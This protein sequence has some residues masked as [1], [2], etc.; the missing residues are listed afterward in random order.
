MAILVV[1]GAGFIGS[2][3]V[4]TLLGAGYPVVVLDNFCTGHRDALVGGAL[5]EA[6]LGNTAALT[7]LFECHRIDAVIHFASFIEVGESVVN[8]G[9]YY[10]NNLCG[11]LNL[12]SAMVQANVRHCIFS[13]SAAVYGSPTVQGGL[14]EQHPTHPINPY[15]RSKWMVE[16]L[17]D[18]FHHAHGIHYMALR[19]FNAAGADPDGEL[20]DRLVP[21]PFAGAG[22][23]AGR[24]REYGHQ[25]GKWRRIFHPLRHLCRGKSNRT[26][27]SS[28][29]CRTQTWRYS[30][31]DRQCRQSQNGSPVATPLARPR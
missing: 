2:I 6:D 20:G 13:S 28:D 22:A 29:V 15:G 24:R 1:G 25:P 17:L 9:K 8:P 23:S 3:M 14:N 11:T 12:L 30:D 16:Q 5:V 26:K 7:G 21:C 27:R 4:K 31:P 19:Y 10:K 18:D